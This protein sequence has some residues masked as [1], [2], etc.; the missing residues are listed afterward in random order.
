LLHKKSI[1]AK[2]LFP[3]ISTEVRRL[4]QYHLRSHTLPPL[5]HNQRKNNMSAQQQKIGY[6]TL[7]TF[8]MGSLIGS[9]VFMLPVSLAPY[10][11]IA[12]WGWVAAG[13]GALSLA[14]VFAWLSAHFPRTGGPH[15]YVGEAFGKYASFFTGWTYWVVSWVSSAIVFATCIGYLSP[16]LP[17]TMPWLPLILQCVLLSIIVGL[18]LISPFLASRIESYLVFLKFIPLIGIPIVLLFSFNTENFA[19]L[20]ELSFAQTLPLIGKATLLTLWGFVG[21]E[22]ATTPAGL[23]DNPRRTIPLAIISGT[24]ITGLLYLFNSLSIL[25]SMPSTLLSASQAPYVD[26]VQHALGGS[27]H[28]PLALIAALVCISSLN[29]WTLTSGQIAY[30]LAQEGLFPNLFNTT[31]RNGSPTWGLIVSSIGTISVLALMSNNSVADQVTALID[32][33]VIAFLFMYLACSLAL[34]TLAHKSKEGITPFVIGVVAAI[35]SGWVIAC[36]PLKTVAIGLL[37]VASGIPLSLR[38]K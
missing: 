5:K 22:T 20:P 8:V 14:L 25:G 9:G 2:G 29:A 6:F 12:L 26:A 27:W 13:C 17:G 21:I 3:F 28:L 31:N 7:L 19:P 35:F 36:S 1:L 15:V 16:F 33:S 30:G 34:I 10:G 11:T 37:F 38:I 32:C 18:N 24:L 23:I 4:W